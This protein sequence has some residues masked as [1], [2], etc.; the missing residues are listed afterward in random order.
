MGD[1]HRTK[2]RK[3]RKICVL[4][5]FCRYD[6]APR[7]KQT[8]RRISFGLQFQRGNSPLQWGIMEASSGHGERCRKLRY[9][10]F[11]C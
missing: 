4:W 7:P 10:S 1:F 6:Q 2:A 3:P 8:Y 9:D 11:I 5:F